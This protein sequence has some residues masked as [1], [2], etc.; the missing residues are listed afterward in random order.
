MDVVIVIPAYQPDNAL[1]TLVKELQILT[2]TPLIIINDGSTTSQAQK[3]FQ[4]LNVMPH[5]TCLTHHHNQGQGAAYK[6]AF[7]HILH[8]PNTYA[9]IITADADGQHS[10]ADIMKLITCSKKN[11]QQ[12]WLGCRQF[13]GKVPLK[14]LL[15]NHFFKWLMYYCYGYTLSDTQSGLRAIPLSII[16][17]LSTLQCNRFDYST[18]FLITLFE[19]NIPFNEVPIDTI[20]IN[21]NKST[22]FRPFL[23][24]VRILKL[25]LSHS[26]KKCLPITKREK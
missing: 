6:T 1:L 23:D 22:H 9:T 17:L 24:S 7:N 18:E 20:Y 11:P 15:G 14:S 21:N 3:I 13:T 4:Q 2:E 26:L 16:P 25:F 8:T 10:P 19:H 5:I 12:V